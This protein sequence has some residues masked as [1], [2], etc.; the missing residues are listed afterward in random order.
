M[1]NTTTG[2]KDT[3]FLGQAEVVDPAT[4]ILNE[5]GEIEYTTQKENKILYY[6]R[7]FKRTI[8]M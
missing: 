2:I 5:N 6:L 3:L 4:Y 8:L 1:K 7:I